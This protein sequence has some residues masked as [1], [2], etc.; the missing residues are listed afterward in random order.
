MT[1]QTVTVTWNEQDV[2][3]G[4]LAG[5]VTFQLSAVEADQADGIE[6]HP[7]PAKTYFFIDGTGSSDPLVAND[8]GGLAPAGSY[9]KVTVAIA[10]QQPYTFTTLINFANGASQTL[11]FLYANQAVPAAQYSQY[12]PLPSGTPAAGQVP[13][14]T[15]AGEA[16]AWGDA[17][18]DVSGPFADLVV[19]KIQGTQV[20]AP[21]GTG[22]LFLSD[23]GAWDA[24]AFGTIVGALPTGTPATDTAIVEAMIALLVAAGGNRTLQFAD[25]VYT[26]NSNSAVIRNCSNFT[27]KGSGATFFEQAPNTISLPNNTTGDIFVIADCT[28]FSVE[29]ITADGLRD[30]LSPMTPLTATAASGQPSVTVAGGQGARYL[31]G[32]YVSVFGGL[33]TA[34]SNLSDGFSPGFDNPP[35][36]IAS[37]TPGGGAGGGDLVTFTGNLG[38]SYT[39][40]GS[41]AFTDGYGP[42]AY[43]G[44]YITSYQCGHN[45]SVAGR[46]LSGEDQQC[47]IHLMNCQ[48]FTVAR[49]AGRNLWE[50]PVK[51]GT[52]F[53]PANGSLTDGCQQ[54][55]VTDCTGYHAYDQGVSV[56]LSKNITV[57]G[58]VLNSAGWAG[59]S[60]TASDDCT[61]TGNQILNSYYRVP[62]DNV[63]GSGI[64]IE[65]G[66]HNQVSKNV[67]SAPYGDGFRLT[68][69]PLGWG[70]YAGSA[71]TTGA[72][73]EGGAA[74]GTSVLLS[75]TAGLNA[76]APYSLI[77]GPQT[78]AVTIATIVDGTHVTFKEGISFSHAAGIYLGQ[79]IAMENTI[80]GNTIYAPQTGCGIRNQQ[81]VRTKIRGNTCR[82]FQ[83]SGIVCSAATWGPAGNY[84]GGD[85]S[86]IEGNTIGE[87]IGECIVTDSTGHFTIRG[88][89]CYNA[90][91]QAVMLLQGITNSVIEGN[92]IHDMEAAAG[93]RVQNGGVLTALKSA[94][95]TIAKNVIER[96]S[97]EGILILNGDS[98]TITGNVCNSC[99]GDAGINP[100]AVSNSVIADNV[101]NSNKLAGIELENNSGTGCTS[102][103]VIGNTCRDD[104][105][106][107]NVT[108]GATW[109]Q[110]TGILEA[111]ASNGNLF[112]FNEC[113][114]N[115]SA[116]LT[117]IGA[118]SVQTR[119]ILSGT[120]QAT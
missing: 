11:A 98:L 2:G 51:L 87:G 90:S 110:G 35:L 42:Y 59:I 49:C 93:I 86:Q 58:C 44:A 71:R 64:C 112:A 16:S 32:Q 120:I 116:Q 37:I 94:R 54:G 22:K 3:A 75:S 97:N 41:T 76:G 46:T 114:A 1:L 57:K 100:R 9:Y 119:N 27:V 60:L 92:R 30:T 77:D 88:N 52:G 8:N 21:P 99:G 34:E 12:L 50:S 78:E 10:G 105:S 83:S 80:E 17:E 48:R 5:N 28:D 74:A 109:T 25:G 102:C 66:L 79:R 65:G 91:T 33:G 18:G 106:G 107:Y 56:W 85:G 62:T 61:V 84:L 115:A 14:A 55:T 6:F 24:A 113:D 73:I 89:D 13:V 36:T 108:S 29:G 20:A 38:N 39:Q 103:R 104:G 26:L 19:E 53:E 15:G 117:V 118:G 70:A 23:T 96:I 111:G 101:C 63:S 43:N 7:Q 81:A 4:A 31:A 68:P 82:N 72:F 95:L 67:I 45:N 40:L 47:G 69:S